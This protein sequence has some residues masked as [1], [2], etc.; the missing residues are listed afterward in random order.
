MATKLD[1]LQVEGQGQE[2]AARMKRLLSGIVVAS[3]LSLV[4]A[5]ASEGP[6]VPPTNTSI[7]EPSSMAPERSRSSTKA[8]GASNTSL[9]PRP[10]TSPMGSPSSYIGKFHLNGEP[11][12]F[13]GG[14]DPRRR[15]RKEV[16]FG[17]GRGHGRSDRTASDGR[18]RVSTSPA[19][20][21]PMA[22]SLQT[23]TRSKPSAARA[24]K[25]NSAAR[26]CP[27][28]GGV[29]MFSARNGFDQVTPQGK[30]ISSEFLG[31]PGL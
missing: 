5:V 8:L 23:D 10:S 1:T 14:S 30:D 21:A 12:N 7:R 16:D 18:C 4:L 19:R 3:A 2:G 22:A 6:L 28:I 9:R 20:T 25:K 24:P 26:R 15:S 31:R 27:P 11:Q 13:S 29:V 17:T